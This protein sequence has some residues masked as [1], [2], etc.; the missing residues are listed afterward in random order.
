MSPFRDMK[1][2]FLPPIPTWRMRAGLALFPQRGVH[3][4]STSLIQSNPSQGVAAHVRE[5][6]DGA[7]GRVEGLP[8]EF[9]SSLSSCKT[10]SGK[11]RSRPSRIFPS[12]M[13]VYP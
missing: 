13:A 4:G 11:M 6:V 7:H 2:V 1:I 5:G 3:D 8:E 12:E 10:S 9:P